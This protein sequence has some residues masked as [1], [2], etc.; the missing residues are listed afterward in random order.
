MVA[1]LALFVGCAPTP[2]SIKFD[3]DA[4]VSVHKLD[5][6]GVLKATV[7]DADGKAIEPQP[8]LAWTVTPDSVAKLEGAKVTP[9][10]NGE[11]TVAAS[12]GTVKAQYTFVVALPDKVE[13]AGYT[14]GTP[15]PAG[16]SAML[17]AT[18]K[19]GE[20]AITGE[21]V[22]WSSS[23]DTVATVQADGTVM[24]VIPGT[25]TI[26]ATSGALSSTVDITIGDAAAVAATDAA[27]AAVPAQ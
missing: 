9:I 20:T 1:L 11:A 4:K 19:S 13:I 15:W 22:T 27:P 16:Q 3:G 17:T 14:A 25:A 8:A 7:L 24:G 21:T 2:A 23:A 18:V 6:V 12:V 10:A 5:Q 26:T